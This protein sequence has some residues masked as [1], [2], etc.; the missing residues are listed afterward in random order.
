[1]PGRQGLLEVGGRQ[2]DTVDR[3]WQAAVAPPNARVV[4][5]DGDREGQCKH[6]AV[7]LGKCKAV[8]DGG[9]AVECAR[10][11]VLS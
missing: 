3:P 5:F 10:T 7:V 11:L 1:M 9:Q 8:W 4:I 6:D 2:P